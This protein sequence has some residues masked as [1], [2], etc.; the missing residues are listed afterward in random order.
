MN[1]K[2]VL[3]LLALIA[4]LFV[5]AGCSQL[6]GGADG[7]APASLAA[8]TTATSSSPSQTATT[9]VPTASVRPTSTPFTITDEVR[10]AH[11]LDLLPFPPDAPPPEVDQAQAVDLAIQALR[12]I[13]INVDDP[14]VVEHG[15]AYVSADQPRQ[16]AWLIVV[17]VDGVSHQSS[18]PPCDAPCVGTVTVIDLG[19]V[20]ISDQ[21]VDTLRLFSSG[22]LVSPEP[23]AP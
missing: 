6:S 2:F 4:A 9:P 10:A 3:T 7:T 22:H 8:A 5:L 17:P 18:G 21:T 20:L 14:G 11:R 1:A 23:E 16:S 19:G 12:T 13:G 15:M